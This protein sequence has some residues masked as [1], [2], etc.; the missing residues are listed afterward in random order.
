MKYISG[1]KDKP[2]SVRRTVAVVGST[3]A[4]LLIATV[5]AFAFG[6]DFGSD[7]GVYVSDNAPEGVRDES[8]FDM[9]SDDVNGFVA[10]AKASIDELGY[11]IEG[12]R[13]PVNEIAS[14][15]EVASSTEEAYVG[16]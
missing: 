16:E 12:A 2:E 14:S 3:V 7:K 10:G 13:I 1:L 6:P 5:W 4:T 9:I 11:V 15:T 8:P